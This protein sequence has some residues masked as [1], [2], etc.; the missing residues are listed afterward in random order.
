M[1]VVQPRGKLLIMYYNR[2]MDYINLELTNKFLGLEIKYGSGINRRFPTKSSLIRTLKYPLQGDINGSPVNSD[3]EIEV[4]D[5][6]KG[7]K[8]IKVKKEKKK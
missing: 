3:T 4:N 6:I 2:R 8:G 7:I 1:K 5:K